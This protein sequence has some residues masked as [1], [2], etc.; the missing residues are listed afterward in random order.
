MPLSRRT[1]L[2]SVSSAAFATPTPAPAPPRPNILFIMS[3][4]HASHAIS[5]YGSKINRTPQID[6]LAQGGMRFTNCFV[7][8]SICTPSRGCILT[9]QYSHL[10]GVYTLND[11]LDP[12]RDNIAKRLQAAG[13][14]TAMIGKWHLHKD[15]SGF[16]YWNILPGQGLYYDP[17]F[18]E[19]GKRQK[20]SGYCT[21]LIG[22]FSLDW[23]K[24]RDPAKPFFLMCHHKAPHRAWD[25]APK[26]ANLFND[27]DIP[28]P[29]NLY[30]RYQT[31]STSASQAQLKVGDDSTKRDLKTDIPP[32]L[33][34]DALRKWAYQRY[35]K[36]Y[37]RCVQSVD[38]NV[39]RLLDYLDS[40][41]LAQNTIV[42]YTS[43]QGF[44]LGDHGYY[45]KRFMY[46]ESLRMPFLVRYPARIK[47]GSVHDD[48]ILNLDFA[49][50][51]ADFAGAQPPAGNQGASFRP[52]LEGR[53]T[54]NWRQSMYY[55]YW[56][57]L[58][59]H[60]VP[61]HYG[62]RTKRH[63]LIHFYGQPLGKSGALNQPT[64]SEWELY[65]LVKD[66]REMNNLYADPAYSNIRARLTTEL[67]RLQTQFGDKPVA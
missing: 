20:H 18:I 39:G 34:G 17:Q 37:L 66:P 55:R 54:K 63:K 31:R 26:Y 58:A 11:P 2:G 8:N 6:R 16:D 3:D 36:D 19:M 40:S 29:D 38:D 60:H 7:T 61:A 28:E 4:D 53:R 46:E 57:H 49:A 47:P 25:P 13:Y 59:D 35:I 10:N 5:A 22:D 56:M 64:P 42:I 14:Q 67:A 65:D 50:T 43:D 41:G 15:P 51:F 62:I 9:G 45:D 48:I 44:F 32:D 24:K 30:D 27:R 23:L 52:Q 12:A 1:F 21:D 33:K